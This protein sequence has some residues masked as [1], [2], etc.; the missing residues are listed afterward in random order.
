MHQFMIKGLNFNGIFLENPLECINHS[1]IQLCTWWVMD[2]RS[3]QLWKESRVEIFTT[4][5]PHYAD[6][7]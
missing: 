6:Q 4:G 1:V 3:G 7:A 5:A 2:Y